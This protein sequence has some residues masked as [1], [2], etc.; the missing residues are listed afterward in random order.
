[1]ALGDRFLKKV[2]SMSSRQRAMDAPAAPAAPSPRSARLHGSNG[3]MLSTS[4]TDSKPFSDDPRGFLH[5]AASKSIATP[6][7]SAKP[8]TTEVIQHGY[9]LVKKGMLKGYEKRFYFLTDQGPDLY[10]CRDELHFAEWIASGQPLRRPHGLLR[11]K[12]A[13]DAPTHVCAVLRADRSGEAGTVDRA[14]AVIASDDPKCTAV[15]YLAPTPDACEDWIRSFHR[16]QLA[17][18]SGPREDTV[19]SMP[20]GSHSD[21]AATTPSDAYREATSRR[22][23]STASGRSHAGSGSR[24]SDL[25]DAPSYVSSAYGPTPV[26]HHAPSNSSTSSVT[27]G[28]APGSAAPGNV[29]LFVPAAGSAI[30]ISDTKL[31]EAKKEMDVLVAAGAKRPLRGGMENAKETQWRYGPPEYVLSDLEY[32][33]GKTR[34]DETTPLESYAESCCQTFIMEATHKALYA[35]WTSVRQEYFYIQVNDG[36]RISGQVL[37]ENDLFGMLYL[38]ADQVDMELREG[39]ERKDPCAVLSEA[40]TQGF[41][42]EVLDVYTQPPQCHFAWRH[43]GR[44]TGRYRG[45]KGKGELIEIRGFGHMH[46]DGGRLMNL[47]LFLKQRDLFD[48][49]NKVTAAAVAVRDARQATLASLA[50]AGFG[51]ATPAPP[52][53]AAAASTSAPAPAPTPA[54]APAQAPALVQAPVPAL[55]SAPVPAPARPPSASSAAPARPPSASSA[56]PARPPSASSAAP[57]QREMRSDK[58]SEIDILGDF[59]DFN[60]TA[61][62]VH[63]PPSVTRSISQPMPMPQ[64]SAKRT[65]LYRQFMPQ[66][67]GA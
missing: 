51:Q 67:H 55:A 54:L 63:G 30:S 57:S 34:D 43:W 7:V 26:L 60:I 22:A 17:Q 56:A 44:F 27:S 33:K 10:S 58:L 6:A 5:R 9:L 66:A 2:T 21:S 14:I 35:Q 41:P 31:L 18:R 19:A 62:S 12:E 40:F 64:A 29:L 25:S 46:I 52:P 38:N 28:S 37:K 61:A 36:E 39:E 11:P 47:R 49:L 15:K 3:S 53:L 32:I 1:M 50:E 8:A 59:G 16:V 20:L 13:K 42:M 65:Q 4:S 48:Q 45:I 23:A 24:M